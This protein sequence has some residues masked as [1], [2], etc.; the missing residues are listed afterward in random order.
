MTLHLVSGDPLLT[1][2]QVLAFGVNVLG[3]AEIGPLETQLF[4]RFPTAFAAYRKQCRSGRIVLGGY[5]TWRESRLFLNFLVI[6]ESP[7]GATR[8]RF[9]QSALMKLAR[10]Y[11]LEGFTSVAIAPLGTHAEWPEII[12][13]LRYWLEP[14]A[15]P[16]IVYEQVQPGVRVDEALPAG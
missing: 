1:R 8:L 13:I 5:W 14:I 7:V 4:T 11:R 12:P 10:D 3:R 9:V 6:R 15:L 2:A 16:V